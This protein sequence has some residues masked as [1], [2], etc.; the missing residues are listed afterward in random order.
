MLYV[1]SGH[2]TIAK[3]IHYV[4]N[5]ITTKAELFTIRCEINQAVQISHISHIVIITNTIHL[6]KYIF[7]SSTHLY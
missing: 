4:V 2:N 1:W 3:T 5:E 6:V 7:D